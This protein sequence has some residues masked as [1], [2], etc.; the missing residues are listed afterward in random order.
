M[1]DSPWVFCNRRGGR[2]ASI[3]RSFAYTVDQAGLSDVHPHDLQR[4]CGSWLVQDGVPLS[5]VAALLRHPDIRVT[6]EHYAHLAPENIRA[7]VARWEDTMSRS[8][9]AEHEKSQSD[10]L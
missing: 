3:K 10:V 6:V 7:A 2:I 9:H 8:G 4:T 5:E 1:P